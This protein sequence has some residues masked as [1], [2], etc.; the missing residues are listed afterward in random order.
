M[1]DVNEEEFDPDRK[2]AVFLGVLG[3]VGCGL[4]SL[5]EISIFF[6]L[7]GFLIIGFSFFAICGYSQFEEF[8]VR[9]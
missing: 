9:R 2:L 8:R 4:L 5:A 1:S 6:V 7:L 3:L